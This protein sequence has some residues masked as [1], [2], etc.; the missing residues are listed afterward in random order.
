MLASV[1]KALAGT[2]VLTL[3]NAQSDDIAVVVAPSVGVLLIARCDV[4]YEL[5][6]WSPVLVPDRFPMSVRS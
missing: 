1:N 2:A 3:S 4:M 5:K 6:S